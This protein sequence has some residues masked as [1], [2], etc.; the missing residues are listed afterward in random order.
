VT[1]IA[2]GEAWRSAIERA[3]EHAKVGIV[4]VGRDWLAPASSTGRPRLFED[5]DVVRTEVQALLNGRKTVIVVLADAPPLVHADLPAEL[6]RLADIQAIRITH[7]TWRGVFG[8]V[9]AAVRAALKPSP[10]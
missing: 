7:D 9:L 2:G 3:I 4:V 6:A 8:D 5:G 10:K 1:H